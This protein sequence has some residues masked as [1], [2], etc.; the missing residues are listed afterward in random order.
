MPI[1]S[2]LSVNYHAVFSISNNLI[3]GLYRDSLSYW[4]RVIFAQVCAQFQSK[5]FVALPFHP[6]D[7]LI[8]SG[9]NNHGGLRANLWESLERLAKREVW[10]KVV[11]LSNKKGYQYKS[12]HL[13]TLR[14]AKTQEDLSW[15]HPS[16]KRKMMVCLHEEVLPF[17][18]NL[19]KDYTILNMEVYRKMPK[20]TSLRLYEILSSYAGPK[21]YR[22][23][24]TQR[25]LLS[26]MG[27]EGKYPS[28][29]MVEK[30]YLQ[31]AK[32]HFKEFCPLRFRYQVI[33]NKNPLGQIT[34]GILF[35][36]YR[37]DG[38]MTREEITL[39]ALIPP[40][41]LKEQNL[42]PKLRSR[43]NQKPVSNDF[44]KTCQKLIPLP[45]L[46]KPKVKPTLIE[47]SSKESLL[48]TQRVMPPKDNQEQ[49]NPDL[50]ISEDKLPKSLGSIFEA[51]NV[52][53]QNF[54]PQ[55]TEGLSPSRQALL[56]LLLAGAPKNDSEFQEQVIEQEPV[57]QAEIEPT[58]NQDQTE[59]WPQHN[60][61]PRVSKQITW[62][63]L[64]RQIQ[65][66]GFEYLQREK[67]RE[68]ALVQEARAKGLTPPPTQYLGEIDFEAFFKE[69]VKRY[70]PPH[71]AQ[72]IQQEPVIQAE[73]E[74]ILN[75]DQTEDW[76]QHNPRPR[77]S[78]QITWNRLDR[79]I[80]LEGFEYLQREKDRELALVQEARAKGLTPPPTQYLGEIDF[81][82]FFKEWVKRYPPPH[83]AQPI[84]QEPVIQAE[85]EPILNQ[86]QTEDWPQHNPRPRV[87][88]QITWNR[89]DRQIQLEGFEYLQRE[90]DR[91]LA[92]VQEA[93]A[94]GLTPPP[95]QYLGEID[96]EAFFKEWVKRY[97]PPHYAQPIQ[98]EPIKEEFQENL[99]T[100][101]NVNEEVETRPKYKN[102][103]LQEW[104]DKYDAV[105]PYQEVKEEVR[106]LPKWMSLPK[107]VQDE[108]LKHALPIILKERALAKEAEDNG[109]PLP[110]LKYHKIVTPWDFQIFFDDWLA[111]IVDENGVLPVFQPVQQPKP[112]KKIEENVWPE[113]SLKRGYAYNSGDPKNPKTIRE[114]WDTLEYK[115]EEK[116]IKKADWL[117]L[118]I[119]IIEAGANY[120]Y[121]VQRNH[122]ILAKQA[123]AL[124][125]PAP[126]ER[127]G[128]GFDSEIFFKEWLQMIEDNNGEFPVCV[129]IS[130]SD[131]NT[132][133][134]EVLLEL[135]TIEEAKKM[136]AEEYRDPNLGF[137]ERL[138][139]ALTVPKY[140]SLKRG[141][142]EV[143]EPHPGLDFY[144]KELELSNTRGLRRIDWSQLDRKI[145]CLA[146]EAVCA[147]HLEQEELQKKAW[148]RGKYLSLTKLPRVDFRSIV[149]QSIKDYERQQRLNPEKDIYDD[150]YYQ[151]EL[152]EE[153]KINYRLFDHDS[154]NNYLRPWPPPV[155]QEEE[156]VEETEEEA[157][158]QAN[159][160]LAKT[161]EPYKTPQTQANPNLGP[162]VNP[163]VNQELTKT[164]EPY[165]TPQT[166]ANPNLGP[167]VNPQVNQELTKTQ[168][169]YKT[170]QTQANPN[171]GPQVNPQVNQEL[172]KTQE[173][174]KT[175]QTQA[176]P[177]LGPQVNP[178]VNQELTKTQEPYKTPQTQANPNLGPQVNPQVNQ[179]LVKTQEQ[180][181][182]QPPLER[183]DTETKNENHNL[184]QDA[185]NI[186]E[187][188]EL[189]QA[190]LAWLDSIKQER[191][192]FTFAKNIEGIDTVLNFLQD[193]D[194]LF[195]NKVPR[196]GVHWKEQL[197]Y[198]VSKKI[199]SFCPDLKSSC[200][201][202]DPK[203][204]FPPRLEL[205]RDEDF[206]VLIRLNPSKEHYDQ[207]IHVY[208][209]YK[210]A[211]YHKIKINEGFSNWGY[212]MLKL[213]KITRKPV[214]WWR[215][216]Q[217]RTGFINYLH[218]YSKYK[219]WNS[220]EFF[221]HQELHSKQRVNRLKNLDE[222]LRKF[223][224]FA[225]KQINVEDK[226]GFDSNSPEIVKHLGVELVKPDE[227]VQD[228][229]KLS[230]NPETMSD[231][232]LENKL[233]GI[234]EE[235]LQEWHEYTRKLVRELKEQR[236]EKQAALERERAKMGFGKI[237]LPK[238]IEQGGSVENLQK[239]IKALVRSEEKKQQGSNP[240]QVKQKI[241]KQAIEKLLKDFLNQQ[242]EGAEDEVFISFLFQIVQPWRIHVRT[243]QTLLKNYG[244]QRVL[245]ATYYVLDALYQNRPIGSIGGFFV[246]A[247][248]LG[249]ELKQGEEYIKELMEIE[250]DRLRR[251]INAEWI[252][253]RDELVQQVRKIEHIL[254]EHRIL[255]LL[256]S[257]PEA[258]RRILDAMAQKHKDEFIYSQTIWYDLP[259]MMRKDIGLF[260]SAVKIAT[261]F[262]PNY[263]RP[264]FDNQ[265]SV[266]T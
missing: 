105:K 16:T 2:R 126:P 92:L 129:P 61:R 6:E 88:K 228:E 82:A 186:K 36:F 119:K 225:Q 94:K 164:Q 188:E 81:E 49:S 263:M 168:E 67:D 231:Q 160:E 156:F 53:T 130:E 21:R 190:N 62:N 140:G 169:P 251:L 60:P 11:D 134:E 55:Q 23:S 197:K 147:I 142:L 101:P 7:F 215:V 109:L 177:N 233:N 227:P 97:P 193:E 123:K 183:N 173:P 15:F 20:V 85:T 223:S 239:S 41:F 54:N 80:Q 256:R 152:S 84:Q 199:V 127:Y 131:T 51:H 145:Q 32:K 116:P 245:K 27:K 191:F 87:S 261:A 240:N 167:Q 33:E 244:R 89:L 179:E 71:Y 260:S 226:L 120:L 40:R 174:Y 73:T 165:K 136:K 43:A 238:F 243:L 146:L 37:V 161:Q 159:Q 220:K 180:H 117:S 74:P 17:L 111:E 196:K 125:R 178:Q 205:E 236:D 229:L 42:Y 143:P 138:A 14:E 213:P 210:I 139:K 242:L 86:D 133:F 206:D 181:L 214:Y 4:E 128:P 162:Q 12:I 5:E 45:K 158:L 39:P 113:P 211:I 141:I 124:G 93:R 216:L 175:P 59:D 247:V 9:R 76:P 184:N 217:Y 48:E 91:E 96:F 19:K 103:A 189:H 224:K 1:L 114:Y 137:A 102:R 22:V 26:L 253:Y 155:M 262:Y 222:D 77:V 235:T 98:Q 115:T 46:N 132:F 203:E 90:K 194:F 171:L 50:E 100:E 108:G 135:P 75:Q 121:T 69:W 107:E 232:A 198:Y 106:E 52:S 204:Q 166:Q 265:P 248:E 212:E 47:A 219:M 150:Y 192:Y 221:W 29:S 264:I 18:L 30:L 258:E 252:E 157:F 13:I 237:K 57:I 249:Y 110:P 151:P 195:L 44:S 112:R 63:R 65:L 209:L 208:I 187:Q 83:Y 153:D 10:V 38:V 99:P 154:T 170:P 95:T 250:R 78:K 246:K 185:E 58:L 241:D 70:P 163:Q 230:F 182:T 104:Q 72:P 24:F 64:D 254:Q 266:K 68:L 201:H 255:A 31:P 34:K 257:V 3:R 28:F 234:Y 148:A 202:R 79:Q 25:Q 122:E 8:L 218:L 144:V 172:T 200:N 66:E 176:N 149:E 56:N 259:Q 118:D 35:K 207:A